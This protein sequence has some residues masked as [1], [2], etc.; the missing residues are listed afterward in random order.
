MALLLST[1][2]AFTAPDY[3]LQELMD[4]SAYITS[5]ACGTSL[6]GCGRTAAVYPTRPHTTRSFRVHRQP[7]LSPPLEP[8]VHI[9]RTQDGVLARC[10]LG[11]SFSGSDVR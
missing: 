4:F 7:L 2:L 11:L 3:V 8:E 5:P 6:Q 9:T 10:P 1:P